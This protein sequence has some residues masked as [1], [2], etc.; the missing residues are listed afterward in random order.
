MPSSPA[1]E[2]EAYVGPDSTDSG[3][4]RVGAIEQ[5]YEILAAQ[6]CLALTALG[7]GAGE[8][9]G[10]LGQACARGHA[11]KAQGED[12]WWKDEE[13]VLACLGSVAELVEESLEEVGG[14]SLNL[15][16]IFQQVFMPNI[17][18]LGKCRGS[19]HRH[20]DSEVVRSFARRIIS[21]LVPLVSEAQEDVLVLLLET[22]P[23]VVAE[24]SRTKRAGGRGPCENRQ[25]TSPPARQPRLS[26][27]PLQPQ[28]RR[29][30]AHHGR[31]RRRTG[32]QRC[33]LHTSTPCAEPRSSVRRSA[34]STSLDSG[35]ARRQL[36]AD[37]ETA[38]GP[39]LAMVTRHAPGG[40]KD[41]LLT[42]KLDRKRR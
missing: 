28:P 27:P 33:W 23:A 3:L 21:C 5:L 34:C 40:H 26:S 20:L 29:Y 39:D 32:C 4:L 42:P 15:E 24:S 22:V 7:G 36:A 12:S 19:F 2:D 35:S 31:G 13:A 8:E 9:G 6:P 18:S 11:R 14:K 1:D 25:R 10:V 30:G 41:G 16:R 37:Q 38:I 17:G